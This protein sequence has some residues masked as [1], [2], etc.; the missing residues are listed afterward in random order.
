MSISKDQRHEMGTRTTTTTSNIPD[1]WLQSFIEVNFI[2]KKLQMVTFYKLACHFIAWR[3]IP[4]PTYINV[5]DYYYFVPKIVTQTAASSWCP[6]KNHETVWKSF[7]V[8]PTIFGAHV[9]CILYSTYTQEKGHDNSLP[10]VE[11]WL[12]ILEPKNTYKV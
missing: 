12:V 3:G 1:D 5:H 9:Y 2:Y 6:F 11:W 8:R 10:N 4:S 7:L